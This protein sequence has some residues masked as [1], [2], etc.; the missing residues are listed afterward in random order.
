MT[1]RHE[2]EP[3]CMIVK[4][5]ANKYGDFTRHTVIIACIIAR[6]VHVGSL[7]PRRVVM[8]NIMLGHRPP[9]AAHH[10]PTTEARAVTQQ[11]PA[12]AVVVGVAPFAAARAGPA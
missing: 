3:R 4:Y 7:Y 2:G 8:M 10:S 1:M 5:S 11:L 9:L 6:R 12:A